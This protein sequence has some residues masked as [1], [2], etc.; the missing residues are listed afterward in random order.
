[1]EYTSH[2]DDIIHTICSAVV[3][4]YR[5]LHKCALKKFLN[6]HSFYSVDKFFACTDDT[7]Y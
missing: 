5:I 4:M 6:A 2:S 1:V 3:Q 7:Y